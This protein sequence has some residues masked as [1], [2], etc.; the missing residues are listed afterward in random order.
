MPASQYHNPVLLCGRGLRKLLLLVMT[1]MT[2]MAVMTL[3]TLIA[4]M[5]LILVALGRP[6]VRG[7]DKT[8]DLLVC[9]RGEPP[10][11]LFL[12]SCLQICLAYV[13]CLSL[14]FAHPL[15]LRSEA[16][17]LVRR[18]QSPGNRVEYGLDSCYYFLRD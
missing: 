16:H 6:G 14:G 9:F 3:M 11:Q 17:R 12:T 5:T 2:V 1:V 4:V 18:Y 8:L 10:K 7:R 15:K 13:C